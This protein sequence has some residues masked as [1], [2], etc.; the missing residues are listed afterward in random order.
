MVGKD[1]D[2]KALLTGAKYGLRAG[3]G[4]ARELHYVRHHQGIDLLDGLHLAGGVARVAR[5]VGRL[6][7]HEDH[8]MVGQSGQCRPI[9]PS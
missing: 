4:C 9:W 6:H 2:S 3:S 5:L 1:E 7:V 8:I